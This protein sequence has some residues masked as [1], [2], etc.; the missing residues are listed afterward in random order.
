M[1]ELSDQMLRKTY[2]QAQKLELRPD[3]I[4]LLNQ[5]ILRRK[6]SCYDRTSLL[7]GSDSSSES[8]KNNV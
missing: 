5:E 2:I 4:E 8:Q 1:R 6:L 7:G 3:F